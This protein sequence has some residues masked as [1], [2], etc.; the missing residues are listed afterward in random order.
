MLMKTFMVICFFL[1]TTLNLNAAPKKQTAVD[2]SS[3]PKKIDTTAKAGTVTVA[4]ITADDVISLSEATESITVFGT[5]TGG[6]I[7]SGDEVTFRVNITDYTATVVTD[8]SWSANVAGSDL[9]ADTEFTVNVVSTNAYANSVISTTTST[10][11]VVN[12]PLPSVI[13]VA[14]AA[15]KGVVTDATVID[16]LGYLCNNTSLTTDKYGTFNCDTLPITFYLGNLELGSIEEVNS[17]FVVYTQ[18]ILNLH[19]GATMHPEVAKISVLLQSLD[20][21]ADFS[22]GI[23]ITTATVTL[24][25]THFSTQFQLSEVSFEDLLYALERIIEDRFLQNPSVGLNLIQTKDA[26]YNLT[27]LIANPFVVQEGT[28]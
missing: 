19:R 5:A 21:D 24:L 14:G 26:Q 3:K 25:N 6:D 9:A 10:H 22:N 7:S 27:K 12:G 15:Y 11:T 1:L 2:A 28:P 16:G 8:G 13:N 17:D 4:N 23:K 18:D 20:E